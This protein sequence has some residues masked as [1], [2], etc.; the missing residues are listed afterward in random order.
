MKGKEGEGVGEIESRRLL[1]VGVSLQRRHCG[2]GN[3]LRRIGCDAV[4]K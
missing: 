1:E 4:I 3:S 2:D